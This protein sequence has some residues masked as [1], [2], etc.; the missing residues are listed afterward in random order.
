[1]VGQIDVEIDPTHGYPARLSVQDNRP[2]AVRHGTIRVEAF[3]VR[4]AAA[5]LADG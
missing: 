4:Q 3:A 5:R 1:V 2:E